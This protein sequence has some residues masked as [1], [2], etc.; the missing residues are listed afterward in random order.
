MIRMLA[1]IYF[2]PFVSFA[3]KI[4]FSGVW[5]IKEKSN[6]SGI[7]YVNGLPKKINVTQYAD[8]IKIERIINAEDNRDFTYSE[9]VNFNGDSSAMITRAERR[10]FSTIKWPI[11]SNTFTETTNYYSLNGNSFNFAKTE[12]WKIIDNALVII[13]SNTYPQQIDN[14]SV[15]GVYENARNYEKF[16]NGVQFERNIVSWQQLVAK[17]RKENKLLF[18]DCYTTWCAPCKKMDLEIYSSPIVSR[19]MNDK[20]ICIRL[21]MDT[22]KNDNDEIKK[23]YNIARDIEERYK[24]GQYP[25]YLF[26]S[27]DGSVIHK[28]IGYKNIDDFISLTTSVLD[29]KKGYYI[30]IES[31]KR[32]A[33]N[34]SNL[35]SLAIMAK[36]LGH[37]DEAN[38][39]AKDYINNYLSKLEVSRFINVPNISFII[40][41]KELISSNSSI[42]HVIYNHVDNIDRVMNSKGFTKGFIDYIIAK[43]E[44]LPNIILADKQGINPNWKFIKDKIKHKYNLE[45]ANRNIVNAKVNWYKNKKEWKSYTKAVVEKEQKFAYEGSGLH[46]ALGLNNNAFAIFK[47]SNR[48]SELKNA[49]QWVERAIPM[50]SEPVP[51]MIDTKANLLYKMGDVKRGIYF[52]KI[53]DSLEKKRATLLKIEPSLKYSETVNKMMHRWPTWRTVKNGDDDY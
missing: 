1:A 31:Y 46:I 18:V 36:E 34:Y 53:A 30:L 7:D 51:F 27:P 48:K 41:F 23:L 47:Y 19:F 20:F 5:L 8:S 29:S 25:T 21:Q 4:D 24:V 28:D 39:I 13:K 15:K 22:T 6:I 32:G 45:Y 49:L 50:T 37:K 16:E 52:E 9:T 10:A 43:E 40:S 35:D 17:A 44:V 14:W 3:Q 26:F 11:D 42:F 38:V 12:T 33:L 2:L